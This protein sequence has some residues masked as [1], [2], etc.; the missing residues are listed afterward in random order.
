[1]PVIDRL[2]Q[3]VLV[4]NAS[5]EPINISSKLSPDG[6]LRPALLSDADH[7]AR[8]ALREQLA[9]R[10]QANRS[11]TESVASH[12]GSYHQVRGIMDNAGLFDISKEPQE[13]RERFEHQLAAVIDA[14]A[15]SMQATTVVDLTH[16]GTGGDP[17]VIR[18]GGGDVSLLGL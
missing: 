9:G 14:G 3:P 1:M 15:C 12:G 5:Y 17:V 8:E 16:M 10:F 11:T 7:R 6:I 13:I 18:L 2:H 4:L